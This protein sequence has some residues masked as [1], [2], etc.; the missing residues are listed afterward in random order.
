[1]DCIYRDV[2]T[3]CKNPT[4]NQGSYIFIGGFKEKAF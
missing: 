3:K 1:M 2:K 4:I